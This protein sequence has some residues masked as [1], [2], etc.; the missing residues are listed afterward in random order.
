M[1]GDYSVVVV[2]SQEHRGWILHSTQLFPRSPDI[3]NGRKP[4]RKEVE[5]Y[6]G[7]EEEVS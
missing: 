5:S 1:E 6:F 7:F 3:V 4:V 2:R